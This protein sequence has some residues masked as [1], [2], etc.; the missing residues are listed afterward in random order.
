[1]ASSMFTSFN[2]RALGL[3][4]SAEETLRIASDAG[5]DGVDL[6]V[7]DLVERGDVPA[8]VRS[9]MDDLGLRGGAWPLPVNWRGDAGRFES[10]LARLPKLAEAARL[11]GLLRTGTWVMPE[12]PDRPEGDDREAIAAHRASLAALHV[13]RLGAIARILAKHEG[14]LGLEVIGVE[15]SRTGR[16]VPFVHRLSDLDRLL[17]DLWEESPNIGILLDG[18]H[19]Y[20]AGETIEAGLAWGIERVVW[21]HVAD[22]PGSTLPD[23][24]QIVDAERGLPGEN[25]AV[26][27]RGLLERLDDLGYDG[28]VTAEPLAACRTLAGLRHRDKAHAVAAALRSAWPHRIARGGS[29]NP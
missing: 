8:T 29:F 2:A 19:L 23:R 21:V 13:E 25:G 4:L 15:T 26:D 14:R 7:R 11:L 28:P 6:L 12:S 16:G 20:A 17:G 18:F 9:R 10:D 3:D 1:M 5:F 22:L 27:S 24:A